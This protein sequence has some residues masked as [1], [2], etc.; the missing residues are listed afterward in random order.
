MAETLYGYQRMVVCDQCDYRF[1]VN[2]SSEVDPQRGQPSPVV[3]CFCPNCQNPI[4]WNPTNAPSWNSGDRVL[5]AKFLFD[6]ELLWLPRRHQIVVFKYPREPQ[7]GTTAMNYI[8]R[9]EGLP[10]ETIAIFDGDLYMTRALKYEDMTPAENPLDRWRPE[11]MY[12]SHDDALNFFQDS[13]TRRVEGRATENDFQLI[14]KPPDVMMAMRR[15][16]FDNDHLPKD[17]SAAKV[18]RWD[19]TGSWA[20]DNPNA[21]KVFNHPKSGDAPE[22][23]TYAHRLGEEQRK[24]SMESILRIEEDQVQRLPPNSPERARAKAE[25]DAGKDM[26]NK[27]VRGSLFNVPQ[28][29]KEEGGRRLI[30]NMMGYNSGEGD[31]NQDAGGSYW[32]SDLML[33]LEVKVDSDDGL[34]V[35]ELSKGY[36]RFRAVFDVAAGDCALQRLSGKTDD[37]RERSK[38]ELARAGTGLKRKG[39]YHVRFANFDERLTVWVDGKLPFGEGVIY[40]PASTRGPI[41]AN[42]LEAPARVGA[43]AALSVSHLQLWR[44]TFYTESPRPGSAVRRAVLGQPHAVQTMYVQPGHYLC[45]G[46]N[47]GSSSDGREWGLVPDRLLLGRAL[48]VYFPFWPFNQRAGLIH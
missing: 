13:M 1:P 45:L 18:H 41:V 12:P 26:L 22:W 30:S 21:P 4:R 37:D 2:C 15:I 33:D 24:A 36:D 34:F 8:K 17:L 23:L 10:G 27:I 3:G 43:S 19:L 20:G 35:L 46:D 28:D 47:S 42:D 38:K 25:L 39:T 40:D 7:Q 48:V 31:P 29:F 44:D 5:V 16:V 11:N 14:R 6:R 32:V 9:C